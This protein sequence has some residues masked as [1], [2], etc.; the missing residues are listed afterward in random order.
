MVD[1]GRVVARNDYTVEVVTTDSLH[2]KPGYTICTESVMIFKDRR[3]D[4]NKL[5]FTMAETAHATR[6]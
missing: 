5:N 2:E 6:D 4:D 3:L 1:D